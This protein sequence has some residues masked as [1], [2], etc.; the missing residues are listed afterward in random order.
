MKYLVKVMILKRNPRSML[1]GKNFSRI[2]L[3]IDTKIQI[4]QITSKK[5]I[6]Q[7]ITE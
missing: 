5:A 4:I 3:K 2:F 7:F 1:F 6:I